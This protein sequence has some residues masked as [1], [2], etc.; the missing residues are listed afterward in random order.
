MNRR[1]ESKTSQTAKMTT[2]S[3]AAS[4]FE[5]NKYYKSNDY[6]ASKLLPR[7]LLPFLRF[8]LTR[9]LFTKKLAPK[10]IYEYVITRTKYIDEVFL[11]SIKDE[12]DQILIFGAGFDSRSIRLLPPESDTIVFELDAPHTQTAKIVQLNKRKITCP[13][14]L[15][16]I[17]IDFNKETL[18]EKLDQAGF[19]KDKKSLFILEGLIMYLD[20]EAVMSTFKLIKKYAGK[21]SLI[22]FDTIYSSVLREEHLYYGEEEIYRTVK[23]EDEKWTFGLE[24]NEI[25]SFLEKWGYQLLEKSDSKSL[26]QAYFTNESG[27][28]IG[29]VNGTHCLVLAKI[30]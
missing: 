5:K 12:F 14:N 26:E 1:I 15:I 22:V 8:G 9:R 19:N 4:Y 30:N 21:D 24:L 18:S 23:N 29:R 28:L 7:F 13:E 27:I 11:Q 17:S 25:Q 16:F 20:E 2:I 10:G 6:I 3:R